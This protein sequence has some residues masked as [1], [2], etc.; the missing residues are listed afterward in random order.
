M[1]PPEPKVGARDS[2]LGFIR[3]LDLGFWL[4]F[5]VLGSIDALLY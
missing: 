2:G 5:G 1:P 4:G 3:G